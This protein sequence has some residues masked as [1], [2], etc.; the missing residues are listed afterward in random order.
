MVDDKCGSRMIYI[1]RYSA[2]DVLP[3]SGHERLSFAAST[4]PNG[5]TQQL[6]HNCCLR[7]YIRSTGDAKL[8]IAIW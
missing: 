4:D 8:H 6:M 5:S 7:R 3:Q 1:D 2:G